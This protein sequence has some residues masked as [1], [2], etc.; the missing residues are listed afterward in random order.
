[1]LVNIAALNLCPQGEV[2][3]I[4]QLNVAT[5]KNRHLL[6]ANFVVKQLLKYGKQKDTVI[7][8]VT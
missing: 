8:N 6:F 4:V 2:R 7:G 3:N 1:V 5:E